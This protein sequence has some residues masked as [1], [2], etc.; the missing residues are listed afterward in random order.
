[1]S[2]RALLVVLLADAA[3]ASPARAADELVFHA[4]MTSGEA[5]PYVLTSKPGT[6]AY[7]AILMPGGRGILNSHQKGA[8]IVMMGSAPITATTAS[9]RTPSTAS[10][11]GS[12]GSES[13]RTADL[14]VRSFSQPKT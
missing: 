14:E 1:M 3:M 11:R 8:R 9:R 2:L 13:C 4:R 10:R 5:V 12:Q 6:P 7:A